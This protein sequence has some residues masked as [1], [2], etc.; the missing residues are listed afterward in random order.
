MISSHIGLEFLLE[1]DILTLVVM[2]IKVFEQLER[3]VTKISDRLL[4]SSIY[5]RLFGFELDVFLE[6]RHVEL[7]IY[8]NSVEDTWVLKSEFLMFLDKDGL[9]RVVHI[10]VVNR[11]GE[12][13][14]TYNYQVAYLNT[15]A[16][17][18]AILYK[19]GVHHLNSCFQ[20]H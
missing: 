11:L 5:Q 12:Y 1:L 18:L 16:A 17:Y 8:H 4:R 13:L 19:L 6:R 3:V 2:G 20:Y 9:C 10:T 7:F 14:L 15:F